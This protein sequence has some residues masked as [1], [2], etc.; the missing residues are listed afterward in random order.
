MDSS[1]VLTLFTGVLCC[2]TCFCVG[3]I[4]I[5]SGPDRPNYPTARPHIRAAMFVWMVLLGYRGM[6]I[7]ALALQPD[8]TLLTTGDMLLMVGL[9]L[10]Q[11]CLLEQQLRS[12]LPASLQARILRLYQLASCKNARANQRARAAAN[13]AVLVGVP[14]SPSSAAVGPA[15]VRLAMEGAQVIGPNESATDAFK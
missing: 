15:L 13:A 8:P 6:E 5:L 9:F 1:L 14:A 4:E 7:I 3:L 2:L 12:W 11:V 10:V